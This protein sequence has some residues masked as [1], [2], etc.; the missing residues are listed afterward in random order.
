MVVHVERVLAVV[1]LQEKRLAVSV[2]LDDDH[3]CV[4]ASLPDKGD[5]NSV[6]GARAKFA[7]AIVYVTGDDARAVASRDSAH[8]IL[9]SRTWVPIE[10]R[11][12]DGPWLSVRIA[13]D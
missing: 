9:L 11:P 2:V 12:Q 1:N 10:R 4:V 6:A 5:V 3:H 8:A 7:D 13:L